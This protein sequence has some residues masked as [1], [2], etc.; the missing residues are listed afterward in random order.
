MSPL[1]V[2]TTIRRAE[3]AELIILFFLHG[4]TMGMWLVPLSPVLDAHGLSAIKPFAFA[5]SAVAAFISPLIFGAMADRH[6]SPVKVLRWLAAVTAAT[7]ALASTAIKLGWPPWLVVASIQ[8]LMLGAFPTVS[9]TATI[10]FARLADAQKEFGPVRAMAT[11]GWIFGCGLVSALRVDASTSAG[12]LSAASWLFMAGYTFFLPPADPPKAS[13]PPKWHERFG[14]D[15]L[16]LLK[17]PD[18]RV[19]FVTVALFCI[20]L[21]GFYPYAPPHLRALGFERT[22]AWMSLGQVTE[23]V[24]MFGLG[25]LLVR[26][27]LK[28]LFAC[29]L[30]FGVLRYALSALDRPGWLLTG[31][32]LHGVSFTFVLI[33]AQIYLDQRVDSA[34]RAR[35]QALMS[36]M[37]GG[38]G[39]LFGYFGCA[40]W[41]AYS[42]S[43]SITRWPLFWGGL[44]SAVAGVLIYFLIA[45]HGRGASAA[46]K[47]AEEPSQVS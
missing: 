26:W 47:G 16:T 44:A 37:T 46:R 43:A 23:I 41:F 6:A 3:Y 8:L 4:A 19:V 7:T 22:S 33:T 35:A 36:L 12:Y 13:Q 10:V 27:R 32:A 9:L 1:R 45:Y 2:L 17:N 15:A 42:T 20:P 11:L 21:S 25:T 38:F 5:T 24:A 39:S 14:L 30:V 34:W 31:V 40:G 29:G 18:H 28:W